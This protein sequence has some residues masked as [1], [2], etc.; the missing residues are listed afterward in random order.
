[1]SEGPSHTRFRDRFSLKQR[2]P[3]SYTWAAGSYIDLFIASAITQVLFGISLYWILF[4]DTT[5]V[6]DKLPGGGTLATSNLPILAIGMLAGIGWMMA[7][8]LGIGFDVTPLNFKTAPFDESLISIVAALNI[9]GQAL[10]MVGI[11][12]GDAELFQQMGLMGV[13]LLGVQLIILGPLTMKFLRGRAQSKD[14]I[15][16]WSYGPGIGLPVIGIMSIMAWLLADSDQFVELYW[17]ILIDSFWGMMAFATIFAHF[18][19][20][21]GWKL[22]RAERLHMAFKVFIALCILHICLVYANQTGYIDEDRVNATFSLPILWVFFVSRPD[23]IWKKVRAGGSCSTQMLFAYCWLLVTAIVGLYEGT[24]HGEE[25][26]MFYARF[27]LL[28]G[29]STQ[30]LTAAGDWLHDDH[31]HKP[32]EERREPWLNIIA[33][34][35][36][37]AGVVYLFLGSTVEGLSLPAIETVTLLTVAMLIVVYL[38]FLIWMLRETLFGYTEWHRIPM[39]YADVDSQEGDDPYEIGATESE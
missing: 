29:V 7:I 13:T 25:T 5:L 37:M 14:G 28:L 10:I 22:M 1:M 3:D 38:E 17:T 39:F 32:V 26:G 8:A 24:Y 6:S 35:L 12:S 16:P 30:T 15:G 36:A 2:N 19:M 11:I 33:M 4:V 18:Q 31:K 23:R 27:M 21:R 20:R 34:N 9:G